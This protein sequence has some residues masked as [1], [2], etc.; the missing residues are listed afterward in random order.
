MTNELELDD[1]SGPVSPRFQW[2][3]FALAKGD[4]LQVRSKGAPLGA[5]EREL[6]I[7]A[8]AL[9]TLCKALDA[10]TLVDLVDDTRA[11]RVGTRVNTL[12]IGERR[13]R[14]LPSDV[15]DR[16]DATDATRPLRD[17]RTRVLAFLREALQNT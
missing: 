3:V 11:A 12:R 5:H 7:D 1:E 17:A 16:V 6:G 10:L 13:V 8:E 14:Y 4:R 2:S 15:D 9:D